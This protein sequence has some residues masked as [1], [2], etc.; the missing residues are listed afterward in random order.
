VKFSAF[1]PDTEKE[2]DK[3][4]SVTGKES[5]IFADDRFFPGSQAR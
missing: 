3:A 1:E 4:P 2:A 5:L